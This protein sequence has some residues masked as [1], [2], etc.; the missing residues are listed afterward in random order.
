MMTQS[1]TLLVA[2]VVLVQSS[3]GVQA[4]PELEVITS[5]R[6][7]GSSATVTTTI[8]TETNET[9][10]DDEHLSAGGLYS[11]T[12]PDEGC[13]Q[14]VEQVKEAF[15]FQTQCRPSKF[16]PLSCR[17]QVVAGMNYFAK[18]DVQPCGV[19]GFAQLRIFKGLD[20]DVPATLKEIDTSLE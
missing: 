11:A 8:P 4:E 19:H 7:R 20:E 14:A 10:A 15:A 13:K 16:T 18:V 17:A 6:L 12:V 2:V 1:T 3:F 5:R 9:A